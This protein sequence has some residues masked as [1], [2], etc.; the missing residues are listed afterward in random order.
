[1][2]GRSIFQHDQNSIFGSTISPGA[3]TAIWR[4]SMI[5]SHSAPPWFRLKY[6]LSSFIGIAAGGTGV[7]RS[8]SPGSAFR[9]SR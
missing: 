3:W 4:D 1:M 8:V 2:S 6:W 5:A 7:W 9:I